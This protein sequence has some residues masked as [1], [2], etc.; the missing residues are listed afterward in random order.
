MT[1]LILE[2]L[3]AKQ[4]K[5]WASGDYGAVATLIHPMAE[6]TVQAADLTPGAEVLDVA[7]G[8]GNAALAAARCGCRVTA[9]DYVPGLLARARERADAERLPLTTEIADAEHLPYAAGRFD[10]VL[11]VVGAMFAPDQERTAAELTRVCRR[12][13]TIA[14]ANWTPDGFIGEMFRTVGRRVPPPPGIRGPVEWGSEARVRELFGD[15]VTD[16]RTVRREFVFRFTSPEHFADYFREY[17]GPTLKAFEALG[18]DG[19]KPLY[20]D[21]VALAGRY[22]TATDGTARIPSAYLRIVATRA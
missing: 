17:Y 4:Q 5:T 7:A 10:A 2:G 16:L 21:L 1:E 15:R 9:S 14:M 20:D 18:P 22:N 12:G 19:G 8:T 11:S 3:K 6:E 13:G